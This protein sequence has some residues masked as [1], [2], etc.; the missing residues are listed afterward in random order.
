MTTI[1]DLPNEI[2]YRIF[3]FVSARDIPAFAL[4]NKTVHRLSDEAIKYF[5]DVRNQHS[6][7]TLGEY[8]DADSIG[9]GSCRV[10]GDAYFVLE[11]L[12]NG[13]DVAFFTKKVRI[14]ERDEDGEDEDGLADAGDVTIKRRRKVVRKHISRIKGIVEGFGSISEEIQETILG[15]F[16]DAINQADAI[17][18]LL[19]LLPKLEGIDFQ[20]GTYQSSTQRLRSVVE[21]FA[22]ANRDPR[23]S[24]HGKALNK[25]RQIFIKREDTEMGEDMSFYGPFALL[26]SMRSLQ[27]NRIDGESFHWPESLQSHP[28][29]LVTEIDLKWSAISPSAFGTLLDGIVALRCFRYHHVGVMT[30]DSDYDVPGIIEA[31]RR[32]TTHSLTALE[33]ESE[34]IEDLNEDE[35]DQYIGSLKMFSKLKTIRLEDIVFTR[36][37]NQLDSPVTLPDGAFY[38]ESQGTSDEDCDMDR[39]VDILPASTKGFTLISTM[40]DEEIWYILRGLAEGKDE[41]LPQLKRLTFEC[42]D[43]LVEDMKASL[44]EKGIRL[45]SWKIPL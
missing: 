21:T 27:G 9:I 42:E 15:R 6:V 12:F 1:L 4:T 32:N 36:T 14:G 31:L 28:S 8:R 43:P 10:T 7:L 18:I 5:H 38:G 45:M 33:I 29:S 17:T 16:E 26:P 25:L 39:L 13:S 44:K 2:L 11:D 34:H 41:L 23:S 24:E 3:T 37:F 20:E 30:G 35:Q 40:S 22:A 19:L